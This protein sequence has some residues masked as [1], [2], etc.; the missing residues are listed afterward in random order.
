MELRSV[1]DNGC[2]DRFNLELTGHGNDSFC[3][4]NRQQLRLHRLDNVESAFDFA[5]A[6]FVLFRFVQRCQTAINM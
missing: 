6:Y 1:S 5:L 3:S 2:H 4:Y